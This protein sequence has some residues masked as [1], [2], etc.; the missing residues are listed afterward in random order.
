MKLSW[1]LLVELLFGFY[2]L[3]IYQ[4]LIQLIVSESCEKKLK[5]NISFRHSK[6]WL[7]LDPQE[8]TFDIQAVVEI[9][10]IGK[11]RVKGF[12]FLPA[13]GNSSRSLGN[14]KKL[15]LRLVIAV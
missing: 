12:S 15:R 2:F 13:P 9:I 10:G 3:L 7:F 11:R 8:K 4:H 1:Q 14:T 5:V 6:V